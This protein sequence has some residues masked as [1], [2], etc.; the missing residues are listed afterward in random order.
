MKV[1]NILNMEIITCAAGERE[2]EQEQDTN[3][4]LQQCV[5]HQ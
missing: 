3:L 5:F 4:P 2:Q 1:H